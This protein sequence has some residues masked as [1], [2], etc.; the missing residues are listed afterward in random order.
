[1][2]KGEADSLASLIEAVTELV[3]KELQAAR[4]GE[5]KEA[6]P[7]QGPVAAEC[8]SSLPV[9]GP[10][11][12]VV[13]GPETVEDALW[14][15]LVRS[16]VRPCPLVWAGFR[17]DQL[18]APA[19]SWPL[20]ARGGAWSKIVSDYAGVV[21]LG[22]DLGVLGAT[23]N[24]GSGGLAPAAVAVAAVAGGLPVFCDSSAYE[25]VRRHSARL[26]PGFVRTFEDSWRTVTSFGVE[27]GSSEGELSSFLA[28]FGQA[29]P[30][31]GGVAS[32]TGGRDVVT[33]EDVESARRAGQKELLVGHGAIVTPLARQQASEWGIEVKFQ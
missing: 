24:L 23:A 3:V 18:P 26:A 9:K 30:A 10:K 28:R 27:F 25:K 29:L 32:K 17:Q 33:T 19:A 11:L 20:E 7:G 31:A 13:P 21:L 16:N 6:L 8:H 12:L 15:A 4:G 22:S 14:G 5:A 2:S 1:M